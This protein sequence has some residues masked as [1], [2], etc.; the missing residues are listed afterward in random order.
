MEEVLV[1]SSD[2]IEVAPLSKNFRMQLAILSASG[3]IF[4]VLKVLTVVDT[5]LYDADE[6]SI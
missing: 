6:L 2:A 5:I 3:L 1:L 4:E